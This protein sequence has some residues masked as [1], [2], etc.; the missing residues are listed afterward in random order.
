MIRDLPAV[1]E[2]VKEHVSVFPEASP[3]VYDTVVTPTLKKAG[4]VCVLAITL[5]V[6]DISLHVGS[7]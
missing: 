3:H 5:P 7:T 2:T 1:T 4:G 6:P